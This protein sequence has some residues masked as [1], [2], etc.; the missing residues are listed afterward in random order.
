MKPIQHALLRAA[1]LALAGVHASG[2]PLEVY[3]GASAPPPVLEVDI[4]LE[5]ERTVCLREMTPTR[6]VRRWTERGCASSTAEQIRNCGQ[7]EDCG[8]AP[9]VVRGAVTCA[10]GAMSPCWEGRVCENGWCRAD[11]GTDN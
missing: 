7:P 8:H 5:D 4:G 11:W 10:D 9:V 3:P 1:V 2:S 6:T